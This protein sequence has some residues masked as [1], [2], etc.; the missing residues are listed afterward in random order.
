MMDPILQSYSKNGGT[1]QIHQQLKQGEEVGA[2]HLAGKKITAGVLMKSGMSNLNDERL[3][4]AVRE[5]EDK[6]KLQESNAKKRKRAD[7]KQQIARVN[8]LRDKK[9]DIS[10]WNVEDY[11]VYMQY[12]KRKDEGGAMPMK[13]TEL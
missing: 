1:P 6:R 13:I 8:K 7:L 9:K 3:V 4:V 2:D 5:K 10:M 12:K 11:K